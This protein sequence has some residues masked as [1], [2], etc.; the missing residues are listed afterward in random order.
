[1]AKRRTALNIPGRDRSA[2]INDGVK[3]G[4]MVFSS[5]LDPMDMDTG[6]RLRDPAKQAEV[7]FDNIRKFMQQAGGSI[8]DIA[9]VKL[10]LKEGQSRAPF[11]AEWNKMF[12]EQRRPP[13]SPSAVSSAGPR[14]AIPG[15]AHCRS[16]LTVSG[17]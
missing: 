8:D 4:N 14:D 9:Y 15:G 12:P 6:K 7:L 17:R 16:A 11:D 10:Y 2:P 1:M 3:I 13:G 5:A